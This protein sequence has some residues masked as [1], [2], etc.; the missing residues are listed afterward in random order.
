MH[1]ITRNDYDVLAVAVAVAYVVLRLMS[2]LTYAAAKSVS[3][4]AVADPKKTN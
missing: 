2:H 3:S 1:W 4:H